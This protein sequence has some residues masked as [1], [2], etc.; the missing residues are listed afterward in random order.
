VYAVPKGFDNIKDALNTTLI[1]T[2]SGDK[3]KWFNVRPVRPDWAKGTGIK[4]LV[5]GGA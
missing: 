2:A 5:A 1:L 4:P 3:D